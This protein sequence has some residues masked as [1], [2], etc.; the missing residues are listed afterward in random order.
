MLSYSVVFLVY[1]SR[2]VVVIR[3]K[4]KDNRIVPQTLSVFTQ[5]ASGGYEGMEGLETY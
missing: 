2:I 3:M 4:Y 5:T 1:V